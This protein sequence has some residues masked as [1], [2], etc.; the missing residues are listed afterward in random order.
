MEASLILTIVG[1]CLGVAIPIALA[2]L[3][4]C[5][6]WLSGLHALRPSWTTA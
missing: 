4:P 3:G 5:M 6:R 1:I 2:N